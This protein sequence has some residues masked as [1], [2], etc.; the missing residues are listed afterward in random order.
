MWYIHRQLFPSR[1]LALTPRSNTYF[2]YYPPKVTYMRKYMKS[3]L[4]KI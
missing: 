2:R 4:F 1:Y 3:V